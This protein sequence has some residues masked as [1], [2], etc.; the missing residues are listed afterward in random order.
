MVGSIG[1]TIIGTVKEK[2]EH[3]LFN[4]LKRIGYREI[5]DVY[6]EAILTGICTLVFYTPLALGLTAIL[7]PNVS[8]ILTLLYSY[9]VALEIFLLDA[10]LRYSIRGKGA[11]ALKWG[12][13]GI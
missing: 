6:V 4:I 13:C 11:S 8:L 9:S 5:V 12:Y 1:Q 3:E 10:I 2:N 7:L